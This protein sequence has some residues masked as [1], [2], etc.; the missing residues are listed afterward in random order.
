M[1]VVHALVESGFA[2]AEEPGAL[3]GHYALC[4]CG[5]R[6]VTSLSEREAVRDLAAHIRWATRDE[7]RR[8]R[9]W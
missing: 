7:H 9:C 2:P 6:A 1:P 5:H 8:L 3:D 4:A